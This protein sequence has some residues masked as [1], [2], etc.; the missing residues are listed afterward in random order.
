MITL[1]DLRAICTRTK[2][3]VLEKYVEPLN[4]AMDEYEISANPARETH[5]LAQ[6][7]HESGG[8]HYVR[9]L[10]TGDAYEGRADLGNT[11]TGDGRR[12]KGRGLIQITGRAN[13]EACG[14][15]LDL[16]LLYH[17]ELLET[18]VNAAR[19][20]A[21]FWKSKGLNEIADKGDFLAATRR[22]NGGLNGLPDRQ[23]YLKRAQQVFA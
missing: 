7:A 16:P 20:A 15:A 6:V 12:Y 14:L 22:I 5:F 17:P 11:E 13:Y 1:D 18:P 4:A 19:S 9:E 23:A 2:A 21:W 8:F 10:A 3:A